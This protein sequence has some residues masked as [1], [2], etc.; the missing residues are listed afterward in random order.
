MV[1][2]HPLFR[3]PRGTVDPVIETIRT[4]LEFTRGEPVA[5]SQVLNKLFQQHS[6]LVIATLTKVEGQRVY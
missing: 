5:R 2:Y 6:I 3:A 1:V 4:R